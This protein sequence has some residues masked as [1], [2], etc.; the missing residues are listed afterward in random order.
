M[1][2]HERWL[3]EGRVAGLEEAAWPGSKK[4]VRPA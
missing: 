1:T 2:L 3:E 4:A